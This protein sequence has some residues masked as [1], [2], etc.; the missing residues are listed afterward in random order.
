MEFVCQKSQLQGSVAIPGSKSHTIRGLFIGALAPPTTTLQ[1]PLE[2]ADTRAALNAIRALGASVEEHDDQ[3]IIHGCDHMLKPMQD[4]IDLGNSGTTLRLL[5]GLGSLLSEGEIVIT[6]DEQLQNRPC[7]GLV[8]ALNELGGSIAS[9]NNNGRAPFRV[10]GGLRGGHTSLEANTSQYLSS[11]LLACPVAPE[12][13]Q[14]QVPLLNESPYVQITLDWLE[15][16]DIALERDGMSFFSLPGGQRYKPFSSR[17]VGDFSSASFFLA[18]GALPGNEVM[19]TGLDMGDSQPDKQIVEY[20]DRMGAETNIESGRI[21]IRGTALKGTDID[22]NETP[23]ALPIMAVVSCF[24]EG[25]T[26]LHNVAHARLKET[27]RIRVMA[28]ELPKF[29]AG[30]EELEDGLIIR[31]GPMEGATVDGRGDHRVVMALTIA[32]LYATGK[33]RVLTAEATDITFP[34]FRSL[35]QAIGGNITE[36]QTVSSDYPH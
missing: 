17:I 11:L 35:M 34:S 1:G 30:V 2:S 8:Q 10:K 14:I 19:C 23:D 21:L 24:A 33:T 32:G 13:T 4:T 36:R 29:G 5:L 18:A 12:P 6:G 16:Q 26:R 31:P 9:E 25:E 20:L 22:M 27:D 3:W 28:E 7:E 15:Q